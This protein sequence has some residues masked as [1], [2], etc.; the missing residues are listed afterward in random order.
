MLVRWMVLVVLWGAVPVSASPTTP[1]P[2]AYA[3]R[4]IL[5]QTVGIPGQLSRSVLLVTDTFRAQMLGAIARGDIAGAIALWELE[6]G[7]R[8]G[9]CIEVARSVF[10]GFK[11]LG[12]SPSYVRFTAQGSRFLGFEMSAGKSSSTV[13]VSELRMHVVVQV[14]E[15]FYDAF[16]GPAGLPEAEYLKRLVTEE[17]ATITSQLVTSP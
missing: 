5:A 2:A 10:E 9:P 4:F 11:R 13:Q 6:M 14:K 1:L 12:E 15:R 8:A 7:R 17:G 16:T 3:Q